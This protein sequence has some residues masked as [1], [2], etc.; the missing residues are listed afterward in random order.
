MLRSGQNHLQTFDSIVEVAAK[1][2]KSLILTQVANK[3]L[4]KNFF[5]IKDPALEKLS[6]Y[7]GHAVEQEAKHLGRSK[8][9][10]IYL[11]KDGIFE[12]QTGSTDLRLSTTGRGA[13]K[14]SPTGT[15]EEYPDWVTKTENLMNYV[16]F[17]KAALAFLTSASDAPASVDILYPEDLER[18]PR[19]PNPRRR[20]D[21]FGQPYDDLDDEDSWM[22][23]RD[24]RGRQ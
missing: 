13:G 16:Y 20:H 9:H 22:A 21:S 8:F 15:Q 11:T 14:I 6:S 7:K 10:P 1:T 17:G 19:R 24:V 2:L 5:I 23:P 4:G 12:F 18:S 3:E